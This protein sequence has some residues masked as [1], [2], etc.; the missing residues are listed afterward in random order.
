MLY[1]LCFVL[2]M[3]TSMAALRPLYNNDRA[4]DFIRSVWLHA[5]DREEERDHTAW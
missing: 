1:A 2:G 4:W 5:P 3:L